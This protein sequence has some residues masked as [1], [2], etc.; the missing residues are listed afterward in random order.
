[1]ARYS[2]RNQYSWNADLAYIVGLIASDGSLSK[3]GRHISFT[4]KDRQL[5]ELYRALIRPSA[6]LSRKGAGHTSEKPYYLIQFSDTALYDFLVDTGMTPNKSLTMPGLSIPSKYFADFLR[7]EFDGDGS[8]WGYQDKRWRNSFMH[9]TC[10]ISA[11][12]DF[13]LWLRESISLSLPGIGNGTLKPG[14]RC[15]QLKYAKQDSQ[16]LFKYMYYRP[17]LP[18]LHRKHARYLELFAVNPY[19]IKE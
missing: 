16:L 7:G 11:S 5:A 4:S 1:M 2:Y 19:A 9:Y 18:H 6:K 10:F 8:I 3:D 14:S 17:D 13:I 15:F 12:S